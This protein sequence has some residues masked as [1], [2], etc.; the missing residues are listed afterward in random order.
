MQVRRNCQVFFFWT[1][2]WLICLPKS[3]VS[4]KVSTQLWTAFSYFNLDY[5]TAGLT[6]TGLARVSMTVIVTFGP[7]ATIYGIWW[8]SRSLKLYSLCKRVYGLDV[9]FLIKIY[10]GLNSALL[11]WKLLILDL[12]LGISE[13]IV[14]SAPCFLLKV[15]SSPKCASAADVCRDISAF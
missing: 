15:C 4:F 12:L 7:F 13:T 6:V 11:F 9:M 5:P 3:S 14:Y 2:K 1:K 8:W 10:H